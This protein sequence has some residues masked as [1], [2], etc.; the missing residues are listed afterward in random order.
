M[1]NPKKTVEAQAD[2]NVT[3]ELTVAE[4]FYIEQ[5]TTIDADELAEE[6]DVPVELVE[7]YLDKVK[8]D[9]PKEPTSFQ[10]S[11]AKKQHG[12]NSVVVMTEGASERID[13]NYSNTK[14]KQA[15]YVFNPQNSRRRAR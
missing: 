11:L 6:L 7:A 13:E 12:N 8:V 15:P 5:H 2:T 14:P 9:G 1:P 3:R 10:R 4:T